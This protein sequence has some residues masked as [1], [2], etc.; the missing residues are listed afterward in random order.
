MLKQ[1]LVAFLWQSSTWLNLH[2]IIKTWLID[3][4]ACSMKNE[5]KNETELRRSQAGKFLWR[6][7]CRT[8]F[9]IKQQRGG[10]KRDTPMCLTESLAVMSIQRNI[11]LIIFLSFIS[12]F[13]RFWSLLTRFGE[14]I[15]HLLACLDDI[16]ILYCNPPRYFRHLWDSMV[17]SLSFRLYVLTFVFKTNPFRDLFARMSRK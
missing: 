9:V 4:R 5:T 10:G 8:S 6:E 16:S 1:V 12:F 13:T 15:S 7:I 14:F 3:K 2:I 17:V 11:L